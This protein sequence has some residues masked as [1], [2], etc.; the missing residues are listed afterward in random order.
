MFQEVLEIQTSGRGFHVITDQVGEL[1]AR[2]GV[3]TGLCHLFIQHTSAGLIITESA[4]PD[5][6]RDMETWL[7]D[8]VR[9]GDSRFRHRAEGPDDMSAHIRTVLGETALTLPVRDR[10]PALGTWQ[11]I[12]VWEHRQNPH[13]RRVLV[14]VT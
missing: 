3:P 8:V 14:S 1:V 9:D 6:L 12:F 7:S 11:G 5:V 13:T 2:S 10:R 4:D